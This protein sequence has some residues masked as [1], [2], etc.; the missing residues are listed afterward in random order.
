MKAMIFAAGM[1]TR[2]KPVTDF[3]PKAL[4]GI[5]GITLLEIVVNKLIHAGITDIIINV[6]HF[7]EQIIQFLKEKN[8]FGINICISDESDELLDTG[9]GLVKASWFFNDNNPFIAYNVD[10]LS[11]IDIE[12]MIESHK[13]SCA[14]ATVAVRKRETTRYLLFDDMLHLCGWENN[15]TGEIKIIK[16]NPDI[17]IPLAFSGIQILSPQIFAKTK[18]KGKFSMIDLYLELAVYNNIIGFAHNEGYWFDL[19]KPENFAEAELL[20]K[21][22]LMNNKKV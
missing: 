10:V 11:D 7:A 6:H 16:R 22:A 15:K 19:G 13:Q 1:G 18:L 3:K 21:T 20:L 14:L 4:A 17:L 8:N 5:E 9:G 2:L 12:N